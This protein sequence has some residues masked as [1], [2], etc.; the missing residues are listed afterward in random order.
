MYTVHF[1]KTLWFYNECA[2]C[3]EAGRSNK[4]FILD[5][6]VQ[7]VANNRKQNWAFHNICL[8]S[9]L[10][11][12]TSATCTAEWATVSTFQSLQFRVPQQISSTENP[13]L[14]ST[15]LETINTPILIAV[16]W[17]HQ[18][19][20]TYSSALREPLLFCRLKCP[21]KLCV[22]EIIGF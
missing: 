18:H 4:M 16:H 14:W 5:L 19:C 9:G 8:S 3:S 1:S 22:L 15:T 13:K 2:L 6:L 11:C 21:F 10:S 20:H 7:K 17:D 12:S